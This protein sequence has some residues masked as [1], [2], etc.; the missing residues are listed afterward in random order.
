MA[1]CLK[2]REQVSKAVRRL[3]RKRIEKALASLEHCD[4]VTAVH[5][6]RKDIKQTRGLLRLVRPQ[7]D[8]KEYK[9]QIKLLRKAARRLA[10][11][12]DAY[13]KSNALKSLAIQFKE[14]IPPAALRHVRNRLRSAFQD[15]TAKFKKKKRAVA[16]ER[17]LRRI[18]SELKDL[19]LARN[20]WKAI[21][22]GIKH[23]YRQGRRMHRTVRNC[24][25]AENLHAWR[26]RVKDLWYQIKLLRPIW[27]EQMD[28]A[29][30]ELETLTEHLGDHHDLILLEQ[31]LAEQP[32]PRQPGSDVAALRSA[33]ARR[34]HELLKAALK[35]GSHFY[36]EK[37]SLFCARLRQYWEVWRGE[38]K[39]QNLSKH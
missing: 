10:N 17:T 5:S 27:P 26:K 30:D 34:Q 8:K 14:Q 24:A 20:G 36:A 12:R 39:P 18:A 2:R 25:S 38:R 23:S 28:A 16:V 6:V 21:S 11:L 13:V 22:P 7:V 33:I 15:E 3:G 32:P 29:A 4:E 19:E 35:V 31:S 1:F 37:P 9:H